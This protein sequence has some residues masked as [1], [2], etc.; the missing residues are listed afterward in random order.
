MEIRENYTR[1]KLTSAESIMQALN[2]VPEQK[3]TAFEWVLCGMLLA[4]DLAPPAPDRTAVRPR[5]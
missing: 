4:F 2:R 3:R 1:E 5:A